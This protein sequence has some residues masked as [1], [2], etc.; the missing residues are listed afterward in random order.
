VN[1]NISEVVSRLEKVA[2]E[3]DKVAEPVRQTA[4]RRFPIF[5]TL[6][7][8]F[9]VASVFFG[10]ERL[11]SEIDFLNDN[12]FLMLTIGICILVATGKLY[13]KL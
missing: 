2:L 12:P 1:K 7:V 3:V 5:F 8:T 6:L 9:G 10:F 4:F 11:L 13:T